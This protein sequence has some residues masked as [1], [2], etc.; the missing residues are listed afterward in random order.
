MECSSTDAGKIL[1]VEDEPAICD[2]CRRVLASEGF[3]V[4]TAVNGQIAKEFIQKGQYDLF[5]IDMKT[6]IVDGEELYIW[7]LQEYPRLTR[8][9]I[10]TTGDVMGGYIPAFIELSGKP[11]LPKPFTPEELIEKVREANREVY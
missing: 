5:L 9:V 7:L 4:D 2:I 8:R 11:F 10:F 6:P 3:G 1:V